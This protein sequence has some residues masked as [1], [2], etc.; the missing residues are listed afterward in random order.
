MERFVFRILVMLAQV[1]YPEEKF[2]YNSPG[3]N[4]KLGI[5]HVQ[6]GNHIFVNPLLKVRARCD[7][8]NHRCGRA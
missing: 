7:Y 6:C 3:G 2:W 8:E 5:S 4:F 1:E